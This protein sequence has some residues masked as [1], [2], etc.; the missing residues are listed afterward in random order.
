MKVKAKVKAKAMWAEER[1]RR[2]SFTSASA[3]TFHKRMHHGR[4]D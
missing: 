2:P 4:T 3:L 1:E